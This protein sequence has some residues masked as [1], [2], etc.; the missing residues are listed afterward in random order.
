MIKIRDL[1]NGRIR[2]IT[3]TEIRESLREYSRLSLYDK[4]KANLYYI[5]ILNS[6]LVNKDVLMALAISELNSIEDLPITCLCLR[7]GA[8]R[9]LYINTQGIGPAH[10]IVYTIVVLREKNSNLIAVVIVLLLLMGSS[11]EA[12]A[13]D[14]SN[15]EEE[16][17]I[18]DESLI[19][20]VTK[21][22]STIQ[23]VDD[24]VK[25]QG[26]RIDNVDNLL[27]LY[28]D[29]QITLFGLMC[30]RLDLLKNNPTIE[31]MILFK[32]REILSKYDIKEDQQ[33]SFRNGENIG[34]VKT[35]ESCYFE[36]FKFFIDSGLIPGYFTITRVILKIKANLNDKPLRDEYI[37]MLESSIEV[38]ISLDLH[39]L[40]IL[41]TSNAGITNLIL[42]KYREPLWKK[43]CR[44]PEVGPITRELKTL[45]YGL[46]LQNINNKKQLCQ[47][48][49][50]FDMADQSKL[51]DAAFLRQQKRIGSEF[52]KIT[53]FLTT[54]SPS[55][56]CSNS[57]VL[58]TNPLDYSDRSLAVFRDGNN[59]AWCFPSNMFEDLVHDKINPYTSDRLPDE[60]LL[61]LKSQLDLLR[62]A[63]IN[64]SNPLKFSESINNLKKNDEVTNE[65]SDM[66]KNTI[67]S[68]AEVNRI[69]RN[70]I[71]NL[72]VEK[73]NQIL[74][75]IQMNQYILTDPY[76]TS[77]E[78]RIIIF[79][80]AAYSLIK[81]NESNTEIFIRN[82]SIIS[83]NF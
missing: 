41:S 76:L 78:H 26:F 83:S 48:L 36:F 37:K 29:D 3:N 71:N 13:F 31:N 79:C 17:E 82:L 16:K 6:N 67:Y 21:K 15:I 30:D 11:K 65:E 22:T 27:K 5:E 72:S 10:L 54:D 28:N 61:E 69:N 49:Q 47:T 63:G 60:F 62:A 55:A 42:K 38:G 46:N 81:E 8:N 73:M 20:N 57:T 51:L 35:I 53:D 23:T 1:V 2:N 70:I 75:S 52:G 34:I 12:F 80:R 24:W 25:R 14:Q 44:K 58:Q 74:S 7:Y 32:C 50:Q 64:P 40:T 56:I 66:I 9:N 43:V 4:S 33:D 19:M 18:V 59:H 45:M 77:N 68:L 39:Q